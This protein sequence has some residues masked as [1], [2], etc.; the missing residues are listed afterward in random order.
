MWVG[1]AQKQPLSKET[2][3]TDGGV[4]QTPARSTIVSACLPVLRGPVCEQKEGEEPVLSRGGSYTQTQS[5]PP[6]TCHAHPPPRA[7]TC[8][9]CMPLGPAGVHLRPRDP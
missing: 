2:F 5:P 9:G 8:G 4:T 3:Q 7:L 1:P 6:S